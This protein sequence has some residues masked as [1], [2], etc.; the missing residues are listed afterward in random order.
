MGMVGCTSAVDMT[1][2]EKHPL[3]IPKNHHIANL[4]VRYYNEQVAHQGVV[5]SSGLW[6][7][8]SKTLVSNVVYKCVTCRKLRGKL[9]RQK[10]QTDLPQLHHSLM[11]DWISSDPGT[12]PLTGPEEV[13]QRVNARLLY[14]PA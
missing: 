3:I 6:N 7:T 10:T 11:L 8:G 4:L 9:E 13:A 5:Q 2:E 14:S 1:W 12:S